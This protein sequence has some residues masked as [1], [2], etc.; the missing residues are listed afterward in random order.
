MDLYYYIEFD[1]L[2][3][4]N[5]VKYSF[6]NEQEILSAWVNHIGEA[7]GED[8]LYDQQWALENIQ[9]FDGW[10]IGSGQ[11]NV[12]IAIVDF[13]ID[14][15]VNPIDPQS[16]HEDLRNHLW[17]GNG[18]YGI[19]IDDD[20]AYP[21]SHD[22]DTHGTMT[23][24]V[25]AAATWNDIGI[26]GL[27]G[28]GFN[29]EAGLLIMAVKISSF[30][31][32]NE[33]SSSIQI[34]TDSGA[35]IINISGG[36]IETFECNPSNE[37]R[38]LTPIETAVNYAYNNGLTIVAAIGNNSTYFNDECPPN[39]E[40]YDASMPAYLDKV[41]SVAAV[42][43]DDEKWHNNNTSGSNY[44]NWCDISAPGVDIMT[45]VNRSTNLIGYG[46]ATGTSMSSPYV[47]GL[48]GLIKSIAPDA[49]PDL[50][51]SVI[52]H[53]A[54]DISIYNQGQPWEGLIGSG[55][56]NV[57]NALTLIEAPPAIPQNF[58]VTGNV[59]EHPTSS[60]N[61]N[62]EPDLDGYYLY[63]NEGGIGW[64]LFRT[65]D[66]NTTSYTDYSVTIGS[67]G[68]INACY[69]VSAFDITDQESDKSIPKCKPIGSTKKHTIE[70]LPESYS[71]NR[72][73]PNPFNPETTIKYDLPEQSIVQLIIFD[74][75]GRKINTL[76]NKTEDAGFY[77]IKWDGTDENGHSLSSGMYIIYISA[78]SL[79]SEEMFTQSQKV[80]LLK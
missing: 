52:L 33:I 2:Y 71:L 68:K 62:T 54:D 80:V 78:Q 5:Q 22:G 47:A 56:I 16:H 29:N 38:E 65:L 24:G 11:F 73:F 7:F 45:T 57:N 27:A 58:T 63:K 15:G 51:K 72:P 79:E 12:V 8:Q 70:I 39:I 1:Y 77:S 75:L 60:W 36:W 76:K 21:N 31:R 14:L 37:P 28:G 59:G 30:R 10:Q 64:Q 67:N 74:L 4:V 44:A 3:T 50:I 41:I 69:R 35:H 32:E 49:D 20:T 34:A 9:A 23:A 40:E 18:L 19:N 53:T 61:P 66:K 6:F 55:R 25:A 43:I 48:A 13:G 17:N 26:A 46:T 42:N